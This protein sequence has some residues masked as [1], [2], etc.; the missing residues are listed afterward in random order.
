MAIATHVLKTI[1]ETASRKDDGKGW[2]LWII[3]Y[4]D[5][6][7]R[8][9]ISVKAV[10]G[11]YYPMNGERR[12]KAKGWGGRDFLAFW[13]HKEDFK[14]WEKDPPDPPAPSIP[15]VGPADEPTI[16]DVPF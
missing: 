11:E 6:E 1:T 8:K 14:K 15:L 5:P 13:P 7:T 10:A 9:S 2:G 12:Y 3:Q 16:D 4:F